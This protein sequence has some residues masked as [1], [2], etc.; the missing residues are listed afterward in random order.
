MS[1]S[2]IL[3]ILTGS[4]ACFKA[5]QAISK[6]VQAGYEVQPVATPSALEF[7]GNATLEGLTGKTV[8]TDL[9]AAGNVM[10]HIHLDRWADLIIVAPATASFIN[11][12]AQGTG[13][14]LVQTLFL[15]HDF[16]KPFV[17]A[18][19][20][21][22]AMYNHPVTKASIQKLRD[23]GIHFIEAGSGLL[24]CGEE[25]KGR[26][27]E[28]EEILAGIETLLENSASPNSQTTTLPQTSRSAAAAIKVLITAGGTQEPVDDVRVLSNTSTGSTGVKIAEFLDHIGFEVTLLRSQTAVPSKISEQ[29]TFTDF[30]SLDQLLKNELNHKDY[31]FVIHAA[32]VSD[33]SVAGISDGSQLHDRSQVKK[34]SSESENLTIHLK[35]NPK[36][37]NGLL[38]QSHNPKLKL[39]AFKLTSQASPQEQLQAVQKLFQASGAQYVVH[40]DMSDIN[41]SKG[42]H[43]FSLYQKSSTPQAAPSK[44]D[45]GNIHELCLKISEVI[46]HEEII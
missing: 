46:Y 38:S 13:E 19:A 4:I 36:L 26:L 11:R 28:P 35:K 40:N 7:V 25:G 23:L 14:D 15:A 6:L 41:K 17:I 9:F 24:A 20:M 5:C 37:V 29:L 33:Y 22:V 44:T 12:A 21:N 27:A 3:F 30:A 1:K 8:I 18:P 43:K 45:C 34:L 42:I 2:K 32:A 10:D 16:K 39:I 31:Q